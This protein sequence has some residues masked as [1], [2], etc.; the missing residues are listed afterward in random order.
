MHQRS[1]IVS[2]YVWPLVV[3]LVVVLFDVYGFRPIRNAFPLNSFGRT[4]LTY[5]YWG[6]DVAFIGT[7]V[8]FFWTNSPYI[9]PSIYKKYVA[10]LFIVLY[11]FKLMLLLGSFLSDVFYGFNYLWQFIFNKKNTNETNEVIN[12]SRRQFLN[13]GILLAS[14]LPGVVITDGIVRGRYNYKV[15]EEEISFKDLPKAFDGLKIVQ[16]S[17]IHSGSFDSEEGVKWGIELIKAQNADLILFTGDIVNVFADEMEPWISLFSELRAP[18][19]QYSVL[20]N[21][22]YHSRWVAWKTEEEGV[23][24]HNKVIDLHSR[25]GFKLLNNEHVIFEK[26]GEKIALLGVEN[27]GKK[28]FPQIGDIHKTL[29]PVPNDM[30]KVL[31][32]HDPSHF[33]LVISKLETPIHLTFSGHTHGAQF[34]IES[35]FIKWSPVQYRYPRWAGLYEEN[36]R[37]LYVNRGFGFLGFPGRVGIRP[38]ITTLVLRSLA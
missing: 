33:D 36:E 8:Y 19:G 7:L 23:V 22:D 25:I 5:F 15:Y 2:S 16:I 14:S 24:N 11:S 37:Y 35:R 6:I 12:T 20:G 21:H 32:S 4:T 34:G 10:A 18:M 1:L 13:N 38:E 30:F 3:L 27:W 31:M 9:P 17:D 26:E 28:P 29:E